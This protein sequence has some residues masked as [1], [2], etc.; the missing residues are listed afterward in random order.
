MTFRSIPWPLVIE[1]ALIVVVA[2]L[3]WMLAGWFIK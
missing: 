1:G 2:S 3:A